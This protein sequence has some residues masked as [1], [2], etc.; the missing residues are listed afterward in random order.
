MVKF[1]AGGSKYKTKYKLA[2]I[3][4]CGIFVFTCGQNSEAG[5]TISEKATE[6]SVSLVSSANVAQILIDKKDATVVE[7]TANLLADDIKMVTG[8]RPEVISSLDDIRSK[9]VIICGTIGISA[10]VDELVKS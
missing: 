2:T 10:V 4:L 9:T 7:I 8:Q 6:R 1:R 3:I 5:L